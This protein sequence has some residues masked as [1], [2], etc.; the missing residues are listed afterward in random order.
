[1]KQDQTADQEELKPLLLEPTEQTKPPT[2]HRVVYTT[3]LLFAALSTL[4]YIG[5]NYYATE[6]E[7]DQSKGIEFYCYI[8]IDL[9]FEAVESVYFT[10]KFLTELEEDMR[11]LWRQLLSKCGRSSDVLS[12]ENPHKYQRSFIHIALYLILGIVASKLYADIYEMTP[13]MN[14][15]PYWYMLFFITFAPLNAFGLEEVVNDMVKPLLLTLKQYVLACWPQYGCI[16]KCYEALAHQQSN[17]YLFSLLQT[18]YSEVRN[19]WADYPETGQ[20][21]EGLPGNHQKVVKFAETHPPTTFR[22]RQFAHIS[23]MLLLGMA[24][25][26]SY[27]PYFFDSTNYKLPVSAESLL[28]NITG[29]TSCIAILGMGWYMVRELSSGV[30]YTLLTRR[31]PI[32]IAAAPLLNTMSCLII[33]VLSYF[34]VKPTL[35]LEE[36]YI[37]PIVSPSAQIPSNIIAIIGTMISAFYPLIDMYSDWVKKCIEEQRPILPTRLF[38]TTPSTA[39]KLRL[40]KQKE[41]AAIFEKEKTAEDIAPLL[42]ALAKDSMNRMTQN[43][44]QALGQPSISLDYIQNYCDQLNESTAI[45]LR[46]LSIAS[47]MTPLLLSVFYAPA[48]EL[49]SHLGH[50]QAIVAAI[51][52]LFSEGV[53]ITYRNKLAKTPSIQTEQ[54]VDFVKPALSSVLG[55]GAACAT[56]Y[57]FFG[58]DPDSVQKTALLASSAFGVMAS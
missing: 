21:T 18:E 3:A 2:S 24:I 30:A 22:R 50:Y 7:G 53:N 5:P 10:V 49:L 36:K 27:T 8:S 28:D 55:Y 11:R 33:V 43:L 9:V 40:E 31:L 38:N 12:E 44:Q 1:M 52:F 16:R 6:G 17:N 39:I 48:N 23:V 47:A 54:W 37:F 29:T 41:V 26:L 25:Q 57:L 19:R 4:V 35:D 51:C 46:T 56:T 15:K 58:W 34:T 42:E 32:M 20:A 13:W 14:G 45:R